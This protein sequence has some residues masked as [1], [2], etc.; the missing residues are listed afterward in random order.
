[1]TQSGPT[2]ASSTSRPLRLSL[3]E[4]LQVQTQSYLG[5]Q[6]WIV[7]DPIALKYYRFEEEEY[8]LLSWADGQTSLEQMQRRLESRF[9][10]QKKTVSEIQHFDVKNVERLFR[11]SF[12]FDFE[13]WIPTV[14]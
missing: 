7:K 10:P 3:R 8:L 6:Y 1:M 4:D 5:R 11:T 12:R 2:L 9:A 13:G 14:C